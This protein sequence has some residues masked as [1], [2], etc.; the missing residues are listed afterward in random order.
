[1]EGLGDTPNL[2]VKDLGDD[3]MAYDPRTFLNGELEAFMEAAPLAL[4]C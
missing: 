4:W 1:M 2:R 3:P